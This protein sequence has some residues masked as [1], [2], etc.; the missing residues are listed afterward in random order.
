MNRLIPILL[1][2]ALMLAACSLPEPPLHRHLIPMPDAV[3]GQAY[4]AEA[5]LPFHRIDG[6]WRVPLNS[7]FRIKELP[8]EGITTRIA[9]SHSGRFDETRGETL[10][11]YG[12][13]YGGRNT[14]HH[15]AALSVR[16][17]RP[18]DPKLRVCT[19]Q[20]PKPGT[21]VYDCRAFDKIIAEG[22][23][24]AEFPDECRLGD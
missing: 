4:Y 13:S 14:I 3:V 16:V 9:L 11:V 23:W 10:A 6:Q 15:E 22:R 20:R 17:H 21:L 19:P 7:G 12:N 1:P 2:T 5:E 24:C 8:G 18:D